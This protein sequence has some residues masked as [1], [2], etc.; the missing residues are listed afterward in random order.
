MRYTLPWFPLSDG[1]SRCSHQTRLPSLS[2]IS[3]GIPIWS[4]WK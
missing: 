2:V 4:Q 1:L 3:L